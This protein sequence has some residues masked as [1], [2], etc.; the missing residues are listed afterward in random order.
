VK[1]TT[2][3]L[4]IG[5]VAAFA[6]GCGG[7]GNSNNA[8][9][10]T[11]TPNTNVAAATPTTVADNSSAATAGSPAEAYKAAYEARKNKDVAALRKLISKDLL[12]F[13]GL[14]AEDEKKSID[15]V[16]R[17]LCEKPQAPTAEVRNEKINGDWA[18]LEYLDEKGK[19][20]TMDLEKEDG[21]W[22][23]TA[24]N[25]DGPSPRKDKK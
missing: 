23:L 1:R 10:K 20:S 2:V 6:A 17:E 11:P 7:A 13:F 16:L 22:K 19:W 5:C 18:T 9:N 25:A 15:D 24:P 14:V 12:E 8:S 3:L 21:R 4:I